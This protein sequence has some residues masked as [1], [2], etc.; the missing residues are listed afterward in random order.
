[1]RPA[2]CRW[3]GVGR[4]NRVIP[5]ERG[6]AIELAALGVRR[7]RALGDININGARRSKRDQARQSGTW[8]IGRTPFR[9][10][11]LKRGGGDK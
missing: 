9:K 7:D 10:D 6:V 8:Y 11:K 1:M 3:N 5:E 2:R 4:D